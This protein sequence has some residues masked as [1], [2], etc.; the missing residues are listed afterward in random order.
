M[1]HSHYIIVKMFLDFYGQ[2]NDLDEKVHSSQ[3]ILKT[4]RS[5]EHRTSAL[6]AL[7]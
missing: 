4:R 6:M 5:V 3:I 1:I 2:D 7:D